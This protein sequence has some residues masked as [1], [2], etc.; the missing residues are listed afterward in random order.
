[1]KGNGYLEILTPAMAP[2]L[3]PESYLEVFETEFYYFDRKQKLYFIPSPE[4]FLKRLLSKGIGNCYYLGKSFRNSE[5][6]SG[7]HSPEFTMLE[8][9]KVKASYLEVAD[10]ILHLMQAIAKQ[11]FNKDEIVYSGRKLSFTRWEKLTVAEAFE[12]YADIPSHVLFNSIDFM[13]VAQEKRYTVE[14]FAYADV[15]SQIISQEIEPKL[16]INGYPTMLYD[17]PAQMSALAKLSP[18]GKVAERV[19]FYVDGIEVGGC[20]TELND[21]K[22]QRRRFEKQARLRKQMGLIDHPID[23]GFIDALQYGLPDCT[24][25]GIGFDRLAMVFTNVDNIDRLRLINIS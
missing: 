4:L 12:K 8:F 9:Y 11:I 7:L 20:C 23:K 2:A 17:Y 15:F 3:I 1:M 25:A 18:D 24:G 14:G 5:P 10:E 21:W 6:G 13:K 22:E 16:G 19:E